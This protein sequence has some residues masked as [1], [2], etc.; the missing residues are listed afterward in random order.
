MGSR[1]RLHLSLSTP[2]GHEVMSTFGEEPEEITTGAGELVE[3]IELALYGMREGDQQTLRIAP[4]LMYGP[5]DEGKVQRLPT[6]E[7]FGGQ[8]PQVGQLIEFHDATGNPLAGRILATDPDWTEVDFNHP[9]AGND[10][11]LKLEI[12]SVTNPAEAD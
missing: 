2:S 10:V 7:R 5:R 12:L 11:V 9:L 1:V 8:P 4:D 6:A 3:G